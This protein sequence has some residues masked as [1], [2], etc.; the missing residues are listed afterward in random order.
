MSIAA[1]VERGAAAWRAGG[2]RAVRCKLD[3][4]WLGGVRRLL[5][6]DA[7]HA[8][9]PYSCRPYKRQVVALA[10]SLHPSTVVE[11]GCGLGDIVRRISARQRLGFDTDAAVIRAARYLHPL[12]ARWIHGDATAVAACLPAGH[13]IDCLIMVNWIHNLSPEQ[14]AQ[15]V[16]PLLPQARHLIVD[17]IDTDG[18]ASYRFRHDFR[19]LTGVAEQ[20]TRQRVAAE[21]RSFVVFRVVK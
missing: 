19:F 14:L 6:F 10:N 12:G 9:A 15:C 8:A 3:R 5:K 7:W 18:P 17:A 13:S 16:L 21:P 2:W 4:V 11:I 1:L 20:L